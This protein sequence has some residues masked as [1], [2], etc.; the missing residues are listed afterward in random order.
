LTVAFAPLASR[1]GDAPSDAKPA[2]SRALSFPVSY[3]G[4]VLGNLS[5]GTRRGAIAEG[6][7]N[8]GVQGDLDKLVG[9]QGGSFLVSLLAP[10]GPSL[11]DKYVHDFNR[12]SNIDAYDSVRL[13]EAWLQQE[14]ADGKFSVRLGQLLADTE[15]FV[16]DNAALF[17]NGAFGALPVV[18]QNVA[19]AVFPVAAPGVRAR[20]RASEALSIQVG[21]FGGDVG[22]QATD[23]K[24]GVDWRLGHNGGVMAL[25]EVAYAW[26]GRQEATGL[27]GVV[28]LGAFFRDGGAEEDL[29]GIPRHTN[30]G[31]YIIAD[32]QL[33]C[34][35][36]AEDQGLSA[37][38]RIGG[39][40]CD[41]NTVPFYAD[42]G[43]NYKGLLPGREKD[44][45]GLAVSYTKLSKYARD[46]DGN[47]AEAHH[48][49]ILEATYKVQMK[50]WLAVQPD[51]QYIF[52]PGA[53]A[54]AD[55][56]LVAG[57]RVNVTF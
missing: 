4:E 2:D 22:D 16:S 42:C 18:S 32:Q 35:P 38:M 19:A 43:F 41:R 9:W 51:V 10:H 53:C 28:K 26:N 13:Y 33:W 17:L 34:K 3:T 11:T 7:L 29:E 50:E 55:N 25:G 49:T 40:P 15:F 6:L 23:N 8:V 31:G 21:V 14:W 52:N 30:A 20:W 57:I 47:P 5:G 56:A 27:P 44:V 39:A 12:V 24:H 37:F 48:E 36:G 54:K 45:A 46:D 1:G